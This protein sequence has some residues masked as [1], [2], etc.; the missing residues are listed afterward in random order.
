MSK[1]KEVLGTKA[2]KSY[3][4]LLPMCN[5][6]YKNL[7]SNFINAYITEND[8]LVL[9]FDKVDS[10]DIKFNLFLHSINDNKYYTE[11][12]ETNDEILL[13]FEIPEYFKEDFVKF[14][15]G[16]YSK[17]SK[18]FKDLLVYAYG[19]KG[20]KTIKDTYHASLWNTLYPEEFKR[21]QIA[22]EF[23]VNIDVVPEEVLD[24]PDLE[25]ELYKPLEIL[26]QIK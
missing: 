14:K 6:M 20:K 9:V 5:I 23:N 18:E 22:E 11:R 12:E 26:I 13:F 1:R 2:T 17:F 3:T 4:F 19:D 7:P 8:K 21:K 16:K 10:E 25:F 15:Q 24:A